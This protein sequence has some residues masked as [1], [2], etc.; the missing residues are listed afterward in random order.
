MISY[1]KT[2]KCKKKDEHENMN[3]LHEK[4]EHE[5]M[6][7]RGRSSLNYELLMIH[8]GSLKFALGK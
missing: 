3:M 1:I 2:M 7:T 6:R 8:G 4:D 5:N